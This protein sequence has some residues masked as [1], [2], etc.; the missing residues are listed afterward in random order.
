MLKDIPIREELEALTQVCRNTE[1]TDQEYLVRILYEVDKVSD[2]DWNLLSKKAQ[3]WVNSN[4]SRIKRQK[5]PKWFAD[6]VRSEVAKRG[7]REPKKYKKNFNVELSDNVDIIKKNG[8]HVLGCI[9]F[10]NFSHIILSDDDGEEIKVGWDRIDSITK[11]KRKKNHVMKDGT[12][13][14]TFKPTN[15]R[16]LIRL[17]V[18]HPDWTKEKLYESFTKGRHGRVAKSTV[19]AVWF[20]TQYVLYWMRRKEMLKEGECKKCQFKNQ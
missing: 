17:I 7:K 15:K 19:Y 10:F 18:E 5:P 12:Y 6:E 14:P 20:Q 1:E 4:V 16:K 11:L 9:E 8:D 3:R 2:E 13:T